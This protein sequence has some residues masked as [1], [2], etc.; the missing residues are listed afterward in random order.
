MIKLQKKKKNTK[1]PYLNL[2]KEKENSCAVFINSV[3]R[4]HEIRKFQ[5]ADWLLFSPFLFLSPSLLLKLPIVVIQKYV[6]TMEMWHHTSP[7]Y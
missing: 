1:G 5:V 6:A 4:A 2:E 7:L 3:K